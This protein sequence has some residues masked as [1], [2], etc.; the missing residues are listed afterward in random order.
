MAKSV[1]IS[2][3][4]M[5]ARSFGQAKQ[6]LREA[7][8]FRV[9]Y[10]ITASQISSKLK[11]VTHDGSPR[12]AGRV[13]TMGDLTFELTGEICLHIRIKRLGMCE[14][15]SSMS[16]SYIEPR[17]IL[18]LEYAKEE[19]PCFHSDHMRDLPYEKRDCNNGMIVRTSHLR[20]CYSHPS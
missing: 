11:R 5:A 20:S 12:F 8:I 16:N 3:S 2:P 14:A 15:V 17:S 18:A 10:T 7:L 9:Y 1:L 19:K 4:Q 6:Q 13:V